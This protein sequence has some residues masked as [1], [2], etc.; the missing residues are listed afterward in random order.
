MHETDFDALLAQL[1]E[2]ITAAEPGG[3]W[4]RYEP[5]FA[6][7][8]RMR[9]EDDPNLPMGDW[10]RPLQ[11][12]EWG[13]VA[14][15]CI[16]LLNEDSKD[17]QVAAWLTDAWTRT[18]SWR[19]LYAGLQLMNGIS[20]RFWRAAWPALDEDD[21]E[22]RIAPLVWMNSNLPRTIRSSIVLLPA[23]L[24][25]ELP[26]TLLDW[27]SAPLLD[28][29]RPTPEQSLQA[30]PSRRTLRERVRA[31]DGIHL[32]TL[33]HQAEQVST[34]LQRLGHF[35]DTQLRDQSP[36][37]SKLTTAIDDARQAAR[38]LLPPDAVANT[39]NS[40]PAD[41][42][43]L[44]EVTDEPANPN[45]GTHPAAAPLGT[46]SPVQ[47]ASSVANSTAVPPWQ[48][49][50]SALDSATQRAQ[51]YAALNDIAAQLKKIEPHSPT[52]YMI[53]RALVLGNL[54]LPDMI[55]AINASAGSMDRFFELLGITVTE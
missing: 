2:P 54:P 23:S 43:A 48:I 32:Q 47:A 15:A 42:T 9:E 6:A 18:H 39:A 14:E 40:P 49:N 34:E 30:R 44:S 31:N 52:P 22:R 25:R 13:Q 29:A 51:L 24:Q 1:L 26:L 28:D 50:F 4:M 3:R 27:D 12:A 33:L 35:L 46:A 11:K 16:R 10:E 21:A 37:L 20:E 17:F 45:G 55:S 36:S 53:E 7:L 38:T 5:A 8:S 19:G 41:R